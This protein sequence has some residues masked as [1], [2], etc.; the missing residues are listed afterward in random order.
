LRPSSSSFLAAVSSWTA[1]SAAQLRLDDD[2]GRH[3]D[4][5][6]LRREEERLALSVEL[7]SL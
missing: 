7:V 3:R 2:N 1:V 6:R 4:A 5:E